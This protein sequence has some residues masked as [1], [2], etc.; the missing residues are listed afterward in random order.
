MADYPKNISI[1]A[2]DKSKFWYVSFI[3]CDG[4]QKRRSTKVPK[5]GGI[6]KGENLSK[7]QAKKRA[8]IEGSKI[9][10][11]ECASL[12]GSNISVSKFLEQYHDRRKAYV[13]ARTHACQKSAFQ[14]LNAFLGTKAD[15]PL[16]R[17]TRDEAKRFAH[18]IRKEIRQKSAR[19]DISHICAAF[20]D[21]LDSDLIP[22][23]PFARITIEP[24]AKEEK[25]THEAFSLDEIRMMVEKFPPE[26]SSAVRCSFETFGQRLGDVLALRWEQFDIENRVV[27][28]TTGKTGKVLCQPMRPGF[29]KW[30][31]ENRRGD[32]DL[33]HP[34]L[35]TNRK[36]ASRLFGE[37]LRA[38]G[39][40]I[41]S[42]PQAGKRRTFNSKTFHCI[43]ATCATMIQES[44]ISEGM[45]MKLVGHDS[46]TVHRNYVRP[47]VEQ[48]RK[49]ASELPEL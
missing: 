5:D 9:A 36:Q 26:W 2:D 8:L 12:G 27:N 43:R 7:A 33:V 16:E 19:K 14:K 29:Y 13:S 28:I 6:F 35:F 39:I 22:K 31:V 23:N 40:G 24:D 32:R 48:L 45:A 25:L 47:D 30:A 38:Y 11:E 44:G 17:V 10:E 42:I 4:K 41:S 20:N 46:D 49:A 37:L 15:A 3:A 18:A 1:N 34:N 21:A